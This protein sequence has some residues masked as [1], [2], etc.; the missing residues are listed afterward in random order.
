[1]YNIGGKSPKPNH[2]TYVATIVFIVGLKINIKQ[3]NTVTDTYRGWTSFKSCLTALNNR[4]QKQ[5]I[6]F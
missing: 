1:M 6:K 4:R 2:F 5:V 3:F